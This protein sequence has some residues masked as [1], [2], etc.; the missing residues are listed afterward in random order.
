MAKRY[1]FSNR[2][3]G[4]VMKLAAG[5]IGLMVVVWLSA[6]QETQGQAFGSR[7]GGSVLAQ[8][9]LGKETNGAGTLNFNERFI[10]GNRRPGSF[11]GGDSRSRRGFVG[12][13]QGGQAGRS[14]PA[15]TG[16]HASTAADANRT[17]ARAGQSRSDP[18]EP[19][20][21]VAFDVTRPSEQAIAQGLARLLEA[22]PEF[23]ST[24]RIGV[25]V[26]GAIATLRGEVASE[27]DRILAERLVLFE[28]GIDSVRNELKV[29]SPSKGPAEYLPPDQKRR[30]SGPR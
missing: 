1:E 30:A 13:Q 19:R 12:S 16:T 11:I 5:T 10:R 3:D 15:I 7:A 6:G 8:D 24:G 9:P 2:D 4:D 27:R 28:P 20:L 17:G 25:S 26:E 18:Y 29:R 14:Q 21:S 22:S 23:H